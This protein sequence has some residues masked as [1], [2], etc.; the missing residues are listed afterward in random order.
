M[1]RY[2][3]CNFTVQYLCCCSLGCVFAAVYR[4]SIYVWTA[5]GEAWRAEVAGKA[6]LVELKLLLVDTLP[7]DVNEREEIVVKAFATAHEVMRWDVI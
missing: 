5:F 6:L 4:K 3:L 7:S 2:L 1:C